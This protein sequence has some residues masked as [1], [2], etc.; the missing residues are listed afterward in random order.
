MGL[1]GDHGLFAAWS[2]SARIAAARHFSIVFLYAFHGES[3][4]VENCR[5]MIVTAHSPVRN[6]RMA[7][8]LFGLYAIFS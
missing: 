7:G 5:K 8:H 6:P 1:V 3:F 4:T 2:A